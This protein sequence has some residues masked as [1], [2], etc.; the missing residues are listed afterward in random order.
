MTNSWRISTSE[1]QESGS[2][3]KE[4]GAFHYIRKDILHLTAKASSIITFLFRLLL[5]GSHSFCGRKKNWGWEIKT[6]TTILTRRISLGNQRRREPWC[7]GI[8]LSQ[9]FC[10]ISRAGVLT[11]PWTRGSIFLFCF[12]DQL[13]IIPRNSIKEND[14]HTNRVFQSSI[15]SFVLQFVSSFRGRQKNQTEPTRTSKQRQSENRNS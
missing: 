4:L 3:P 13:N 12:K 15:F 10:P 2:H 6:T 1:E 9:V 5:G 7:C 8:F 14:R 11:L